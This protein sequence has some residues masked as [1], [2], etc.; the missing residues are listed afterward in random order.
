MI[1]CRN[2]TWAGKRVVY[3][4]KDLG[5]TWEPHTT[6]CSAL[7]EPTCQASI[8]AVNSPKYGRLLLFSNPK[9][10]PRSV[11]TVRAS[12]DDGKTWNE[13][14]LYDTRR[15]MGYSCLAMVDDEHVGVIYETC[16][17]NGKNGNRG[18]GFVILPLADIVNAQ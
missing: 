16:H 1:N 9:V 15:C 18:I 17:N 10:Y 5:K 6:N 3:I 8:I 12:K 11:M 13:G 7:V 2:E 14:L 4:T